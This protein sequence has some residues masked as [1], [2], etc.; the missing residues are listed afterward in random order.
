MTLKKVI[1]LVGIALASTVLV[2][3]SGQQVD[4][5]TLTIGVMTKTSSDQARW[6]KVEELLK[7]DK[8]TLK[9]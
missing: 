3:C 7:K 4:K 2:A 5:N 6:D 9:Y 8:I 1:G